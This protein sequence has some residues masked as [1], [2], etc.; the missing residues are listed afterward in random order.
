MALAGKKIV[1]VGG[2]SGLGLAT[3]RA[4][5][6]Q[7]ADVIVTSVS[8]QQ[9]REVMDKHGFKGGLLD[10]TREDE[11]SAF[12]GDVGAFD[13]LAIS[14]GDPLKKTPFLKQTAEGARKDFEIRF[15]GA[16]CAVRHAAPNIRPG[17]SITLTSGLAGRRATPGI[18]V[19]GAVCGA[20]ES[21]AQGLAVELAPIRVNVVCPGVVDTGIWDA[22]P[23]AARNGF[24]A[25][26]GKALPIGRVGRPEELAEAY[27]YLM[28]NSFST[29]AIVVADGGG[30][31]AG[32]H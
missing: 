16:H 15:W 3:A 4:A 7:G 30:L 19:L 32:P 9:L 11:V 25:D 21:L 20:V 12:F 1:L 5:R 23:D 22:L 2:A 29:G 31:H 24:Y 27:L 14:A 8:Q 13:H 17:G 26:T 18:A 10:V 28:R 6:A